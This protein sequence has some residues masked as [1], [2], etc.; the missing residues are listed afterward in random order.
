MLFLVL[1]DGTDKVKAKVDND[2]GNSS[3]TVG[4]DDMSICYESERKRYGNGQFSCYATLMFIVSF[5]RLMLRTFF[6]N[7]YT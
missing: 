1:L 3:M 2:N 6:A 7:V 5:Y 4:Q